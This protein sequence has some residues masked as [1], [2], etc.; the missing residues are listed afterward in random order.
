M[1][2]WFYGKNNEV[3]VLINTFSVHDNVVVAFYSRSLRD[4]M[5]LTSFILPAGMRELCSVSAGLK[6]T[7]LKH[8]VIVLRLTKIARNM[9]DIKTVPQFCFV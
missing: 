3:R 5:R 7:T 4:T 2:Q 9:T 6:I 8:L 1:G